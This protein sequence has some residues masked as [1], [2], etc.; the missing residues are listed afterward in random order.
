MDIRSDNRA[1]NPYLAGALV[2]V[3]AVLS[4]LVTTKALGKSHY[5]GASTTFVRVAGLVEKQFAPEHVEKNEYFQAKKVKVD[6]QMMLV[7]GIF[8][9]A[10]AASFA[11]GSFK[12][13]SVPPMWAEKFGNSVATRA[14][15]AFLGGIVA[16][17]GARLAGGC[18]S[19]HGLSGNMQLA[20]SGLVTMV[21][22]LAGGL[23]TAKIIY[24]GKK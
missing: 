2:G 5:L 15:G 21:F 18:P 3:L 17:Y 6:W 14:I 8:F 20:A 22:F 19:G 11:D 9:G 7:V 13:E 4:V 24:G 10:L 16:M 12:L 23:I 1:W